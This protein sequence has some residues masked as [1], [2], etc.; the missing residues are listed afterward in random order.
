[1]MKKITALLLSLLLLGSMMSFAVAAEPFSVDGS[2]YLSGCAIATTPEGNR[3]VVVDY[4][5]YG[6][7][8]MTKLGATQVKIE[9]YDGED[10]VYYTTLPG[11]STKNDVSHSATVSFYG[12]VGVKYRPVI[13]AYAEDATGSDSRAYTGTGVACK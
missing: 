5:V 12:T 7:G 1:M 10:W 9:R 6:T 11:S 2:A 8:E 4:T 3:K 13:Y